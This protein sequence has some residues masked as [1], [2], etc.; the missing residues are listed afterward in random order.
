MSRAC[1]RLHSFPSP[2][3]SI[4]LH[5]SPASH[6]DLLQSSSR[7]SGAIVY[8]RSSSWP[9]A[10]MQCQLVKHDWLWSSRPSG[11]M[12][13]AKPRTYNLQQ[14]GYNRSYIEC[15]MSMP[16]CPPYLESNLPK[17]RGGFV[18]KQASKA[19]SSNC[20]DLLTRQKT[21]KKLCDNRNF[22]FSIYIFH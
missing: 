15:R 1:C 21:A 17:D 5:P 11:S 16:S 9:S 19:N 18:C 6:P 20:L 12:K 22:F 13:K 8:L 14:D 10:L 3:L 2:F 4:F 7:I